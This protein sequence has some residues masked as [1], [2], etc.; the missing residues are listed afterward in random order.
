MTRFLIAFIALFL[1]ISCEEDDVVSKKG[2]LEFT[3]APDEALSGGRINQSASSLLVTIEDAQGN[4]IH[5]RKEIPLFKFGEEYL[6][7]PI[8]LTSGNFKLREFIVL[9]E[10][11]VTIY[12][13]PLEGSPLAYLV[14]N[15]LPIDLTITKNN[16]TR[17]TPQV[18]KVEGNSSVDFGYATFSFD[19]VNT[20]TFSAGIMIYNSTGKTFELAGASVKIISGE[21]TLYH[22]EVPA[23]TNDIR[24]KD[25]YDNYSLTVTK[26]GYG[27]YERDFTA[28]EL[29]SYGTGSP[30]IITLLSQSLT[31]GL[32]AYYPFNGNA[33]DE[34]QNDFHGIVHNAA[35][36]TNRNGVPNSAYSFDGI[37]DYVQVPHDEALNL[38]A[39]FSI[40]LWTEV[41]DAQEA[42]NGIN[43]ILRKWSGNAEGY[44]FGISYLNPLADDAKEDKILYARYDSQLCGNILETHSTSV[45]NNTFIHIVMVK[46]GDKVRHYLNNQMIA[47]VTDPSTCTTA[48]TADM[49]IGCRGNLVRF[50][51]GK[52]DDIRIYNR[53]LTEN[54]VTQLS[55]E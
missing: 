2:R 22:M 34:S 45:T 40:S 4:I 44:P 39:N 35:L 42:E 53:A 37:D 30:L 33:N 17:I 25:G 28:T 50:F 47:E 24:V 54:E 32:I 14:E 23:L 10:N 11:D 5:E 48:N 12:A 43:D 46:E 20:L 52:I 41:S 29:K 6:S 1:T 55:G 26:D 38:E 19:V 36:T 51:K 49:T 27:S 8:A 3:F 31:D 13:T 16:L 9:D 18:I 7:E 21:E 15:P